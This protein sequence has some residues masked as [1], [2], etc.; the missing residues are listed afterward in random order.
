METIFRSKNDR[1]LKESFELS[2]SLNSAFTR[3]FKNKIETELIVK[4]QFKKH[5]DINGRYNYIPY[6]TK[7][8]IEKLFSVRKYLISKNK[9]HFPV[10]F[11]DCGCGIGSTLFIA[12]KLGYESYGLEIDNNCIKK[13]KEIFYD[14]NIKKAD[15]L[16]YKNY[17]DFD[18]IYFFKPLCDDKK[19]EQF[20]KYIANKSKV[21]T[22]IISANNNSYVLDSDSRF[23]KIKINNNNFYI[24]IKEEK[25]NQLFIQ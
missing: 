9:W 2:S 25:K 19:E 21:G 18:V 24:K 10:K 20:E 15:I 16:R 17:K 13:A 11:L 5:Y 6:T 4:N 3:F 1:F 12:K 22:I 8:F 23:K 7:N 14:L